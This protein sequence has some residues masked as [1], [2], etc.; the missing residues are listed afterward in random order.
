MPIASHFTSVFEQNWK[1]NFTQCTPNGN[2]KYTDLCNLL[3]ITAASHSEIGGISFKDMQLFHQAWVL[4]RMRVE[5]IF[6]LDG[7]IQ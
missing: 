3:Q 5:L 6:Y 1:I 2:L 4:S 7:T